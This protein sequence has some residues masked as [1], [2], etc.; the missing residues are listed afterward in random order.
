MEP[1][2]LC[3]KVRSE[4][5]FDAYHMQLKV[6]FRCCC[7]RM[8]LYILYMHNF[9][10]CALC[11]NFVLCVQVTFLLLLVLLLFLLS[12][13]SFF[14]SFLQRNQRVRSCG[15]QLPRLYRIWTAV[16]RLYQGQLEHK[17]VRG[18]WFQ[19]QHPFLSLPLS[20][21][22]VCACVRMSL[23]MNLPVVHCVFT[24][25]LLCTHL[26]LTMYLPVTHY[27]LTCHSLC[28]HP[29]FAMCTCVYVTQDCIAA[30]DFALNNF[31]YLDSE[32][33]AALGASYGERQTA[34]N[35][36]ST[37]TLSFFSLA[38]TLTHTHTLL[39]GLHDEYH[40]WQ[41]PTLQVPRQPRRNI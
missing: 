6:S 10:C 25:H 9:A 31:P 19:P 1:C 8:T 30:V 16:L 40:Q 32:G 7:C 22:L 13:L 14:S 15:G 38:H 24:C 39:R 20:F 4:L 3:S 21:P 29:S 36:C 28:T 2:V 33:V 23:T 17:T 27:V 26:S 37:V 34:D 12:L 5:L 35:L 41:N 18:A 11:S